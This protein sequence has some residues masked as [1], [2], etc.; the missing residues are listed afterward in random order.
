MKQKITPK[1][2]KFCEEYL[3]DL[4]ATQAAIRAG[5]SVKT[6]NRI[7]SRMLSKV[8]IQEKIHELQR[9]AREKAE[10][11]KEEIL[12]ELSLIIR[13]KVS[14]FDNSKNEIRDF[15]LLSKS[16]IQ[17]I[18]TFNRMLGYDAPSD[19]NLTLEQFPEPV[20]DALIERLMKK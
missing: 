17:A 11:T 14:D 7:A 2:E 4:N 19:I 20:L 13:S 6:A 1:Q 16:K 15:S 18:Q 3:V 10:I 5:Y 8:D 9:L 12:K